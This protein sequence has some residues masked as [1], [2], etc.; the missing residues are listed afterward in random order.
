MVEKY[1]KRIVFQPEYYGETQDH[2]F[3]NTSRD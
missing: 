3:N 2:P 1:K